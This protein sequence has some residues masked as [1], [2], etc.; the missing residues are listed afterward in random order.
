MLKEGK[1][2][3]PQIIRSCLIAGPSDAAWQVVAAALKGTDSK[4]EDLEQFGLVGTLPCSGA[5]KMKMMSG[6][7]EAAFGGVP[8]SLTELMAVRSALD[9]AGADGSPDAA[10]EAFKAAT[11]PKLEKI[12]SISFSRATMCTAADFA[13]STSGF[14]ASV[15]AATVSRVA[16]LFIA[17]VEG[18]DAPAPCIAAL[19]SWVVA[20]LASGMCDD[21]FP[22]P[23]FAALVSSKVFT[24][25]AVAEWKASALKRSKSLQ[26]L[27]AMLK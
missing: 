22:G 15:A 18:C 9:A 6:K 13:L 16:P 1:A 17:A 23:F 24:V 21:D 4:L 12:A 8:K 27:A 2:T 19:G 10:V 14:N 3:A 26:S 5:R 20:Q 7:I 25:A 11:T